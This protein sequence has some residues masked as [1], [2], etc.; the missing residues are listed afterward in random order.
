MT[1]QAQDDDSEKE[2]DGANGKGDDFEHAWGENC[3]M[4]KW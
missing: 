1:G 4:R 2:L 3:T